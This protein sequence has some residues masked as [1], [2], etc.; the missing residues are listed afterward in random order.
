MRVNQ[1][2]F[3]EH[4]NKLMEKHWVLLLCARI[5]LYES[6]TYIYSL[7]LTAITTAVFSIMAAI[8]SIQ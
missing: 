5:A 8:A 3:V 7:S 1:H 6:Y 2:M 4:S